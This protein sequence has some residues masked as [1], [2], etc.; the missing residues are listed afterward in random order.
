MGRPHK[1]KKIHQIEDEYCN[2][3]KFGQDWTENKKFFII[4]QKEVRTPFLKNAASNNDMVHFNVISNTA[5]A[6]L[7]Y[8]LHKKQ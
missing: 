1:D 6:V 7:F 4:G 2:L 5:S 8:L 3:T